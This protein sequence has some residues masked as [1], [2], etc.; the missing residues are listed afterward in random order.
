MDFKGKIKTIS[1]EIT[2]SLPKQAS[3]SE[4]KEILRSYRN[5]NYDGKKALIE[6]ETSKG[7]KSLI[8]PSV[9]D[10]KY[11][12]ILN[13]YLESISF[14]DKYKRVLKSQKDIWKE[15]LENSAGI[16][17]RK[18]IVLW[19]KKSYEKIICSVCLRVGHHYEHCLFYPYRINNFAQKCTYRQALSSFIYQY[20]PVEWSFSHMEPAKVK[21]QMEVDRKRLKGIQQEFWTNFTK[22]SGYR[23]RKFTETYSPLLNFIGMWYI[24]TSKGILI[25][26]VSGFRVPFT[27]SPP[28]YEVPPKRNWSKKERQEYEAHLSKL[29]REKKISIVP[30][31]YPKRVLPTFL[32]KQKD[33][34]RFIL[35]AVSLNCY[36]PIERFRLITMV[37]I[38][39][40]TEFYNEKYKP[41]YMSIDARSAYFLMVLD[42]EST[43]YLCFSYRDEKGKTWYFTFLGYPFGL[44]NAC[45]RFQKFFNAPVRFLS[46]YF[47]S[48]FQYLDDILIQLLI[49]EKDFVDYQRDF[50]LWLYNELGVYINDKSIVKP[51]Q[52]IQYIG[53]IIDNVNER[54]DPSPERL[55]KLLRMIGENLFEE[56]MTIKCITR[57]MGIIV[58]MRAV[59]RFVQVLTKAI[60]VFLSEKS[61]A[62]EG[63]QDDFYKLEVYIPEEVKFAIIQF[64]SILDRHLKQKGVKRGRQLGVLKIFSDT[65]ET[66]SGGYYVLKDRPSHL[67]SCKLPQSFIGV[68]S[69]LRELKGILNFLTSVV[70]Q[71]KGKSE[72]FS[73]I[74]IFCDNAAAILGI[75][76]S[77]SK[78][79][80]SRAI[81]I[82]IHE[83]LNSLRKFYSCFWARRDSIC[84]RIADSLSRPPVMNQDNYSKFFFEKIKKFYGS[85]PSQLLSHDQL[86]YMSEWEHI[87]SYKCRCGK[88]H[89][90][91][92]IQRELYG[93]ESIIITPMSSLIIMN[94]I[95]FIK[96]RKMKGLLI[97]PFHYNSVY[98]SMLKKS[99]NVKGPK[100]LPSKDLY[101]KGSKGIYDRFLALFKFNFI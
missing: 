11:L 26:M 69:T 98:F 37:K 101:I 93:K 21:A 68:S 44:R 58:S 64:L 90:M 34:Y 54:I 46:R 97:T 28:K 65:G 53:F 29:L 35:N 9:W 42:P 73:E 16:T 38:I 6:M 99:K 50:V 36:I 82:E 43:K 22:F 30:C 63:N 87:C 52:S 15:I 17:E 94:I 79:K 56:K 13:P 66:H 49:G 7:I 76:G 33:K 55:E 45:F 71:I 3:I 27:T 18:K 57:I 74:Q 12:D 59:F 100:V 20:R 70:S 78:D 25:S 8:S 19:G 1:K 95:N 84:I 88:P 83:I 81:I 31:W 32:L 86:K 80:R 89:S 67:I 23:K 5:L 77:S 61:I 24:G 10:P 40:A 85:V 62:F 2:E 4:N 47:N 51:S 14:V 72:E 48:L 75:L 96:S 91:R 39:E 60:S 41:F 92:L